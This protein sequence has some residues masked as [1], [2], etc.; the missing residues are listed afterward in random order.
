MELEFNLHTLADSFRFERDGSLII[1]YVGR[2]TN[3]SMEVSKEMVYKSLT[4]T[5]N[6]ATKIKKNCW[7]ER[8]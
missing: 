6:I 5:K 7:W 3:V 1:D 8:Y 4:N 2:D